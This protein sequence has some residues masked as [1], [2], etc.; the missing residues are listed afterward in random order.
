[1]SPKGKAGCFVK[2]QDVPLKNKLS[3]MMLLVVIEIDTNVTTSTISC[4]CFQGKHLS[5]EE[6]VHL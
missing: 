4:F 2:A 3:L 5:K 6:T 1:M